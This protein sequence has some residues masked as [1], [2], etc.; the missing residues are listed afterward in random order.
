MSAMT[1]PTVM[2]AIVTAVVIV[3]PVVRTVIVIARIPVSSV[4]VKASIRPLVIISIRSIVRAVI[5]EAE[6]AVAIAETVTSKMPVM[7]VAS[8]MI[9]SIIMMATSM[10]PGDKFYRHIAFSLESVEIMIGC[11]QPGILNI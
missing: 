10:P 6:P 9:A 8:V 11:C 4:V 2:P 5:F 3:S 7:T 1:A